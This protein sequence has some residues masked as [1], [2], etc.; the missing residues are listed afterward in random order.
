[1]MDRCIHGW[2]DWLKFTLLAGFGMLRACALHN[3]NINNINIANMITQL[4]LTLIADSFL[5]NSK[6]K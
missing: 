6:C 2:E 5:F 1:M 4:T 3:D